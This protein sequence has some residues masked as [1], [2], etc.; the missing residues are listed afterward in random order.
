LETLTHSENIADEE[1]IEAFQ[2]E[3]IIDNHISPEENV[4]E[5]IS[6][7]RSVAGVDAGLG[8]GASEHAVLPEALFNEPVAEPDRVEMGESSDLQITASAVVEHDQESPD[9]E[10]TEGEPVDALAPA[11]AYD[12]A[13]A[14]D[15]QSAVFSEVAP[16]PMASQPAVDPNEDP[17]D[18]FEP[19]ADPRLPSVM[20]VP[21]AIAAPWSDGEPARASIPL[22]ALPLSAATSAVVLA[23]AHPASASALRL[24]P[25]APADAAPQ[26]PASDPL[27]P[28]RALSAEELI[29][30]FS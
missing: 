3:G 10:L 4:H 5:H 25:V 13:P 26:P 24:P 1:T 29:A 19:D 27:A 28:I 11:A 16:E 9:T 15:E 12:E 14:Q 17:G 21:A 8:D 20:P 23:E 7:G 2:P 18:L 22:D 6:D 30:L